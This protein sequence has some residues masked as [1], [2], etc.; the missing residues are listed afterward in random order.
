MHKANLISAFLTG[1]V[2]SLSCLTELAEL[3]PQRWTGGARVDT[4]ALSPDLGKT[5]HFP[6]LSIAWA[7]G[8]FG[9]FLHQVKKAPLYDCCTGG[10]RYNWLLTSVKCFLASLIWSH[11]MA[12]WLISEWW[13]SL[14]SSDKLHLVSNIL[15]FPCCSAF[16]F[17]N[18]LL[19][20][21][22]AKFMKH[23]DWSSRFFSVLSLSGFGGRGD[24]PFIR[25]AQKHP[26]FCLLGETG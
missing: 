15:L 13:T 26:V 3:L 12:H 2:F 21:F 10:F 11:H 20:I 23:T 6:P 1:Y 19:M 25:W 16:D 9:S 4:S 17:V 22:Y 14:A 5:F 24:S 7:I 8:F 18:I